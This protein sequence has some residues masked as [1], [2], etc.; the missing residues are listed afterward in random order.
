MK[1]LRC[2]SLN[3]FR[4]L[5]AFGDKRLFCK[6]CNLSWLEQSVIEFGRL[7]APNMEKLTFYQNNKALRSGI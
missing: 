5:D 1:C 6:H 4:F 7:K 3:T 2:K